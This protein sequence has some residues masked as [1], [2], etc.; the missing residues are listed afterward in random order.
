MTTLTFIENLRKIAEVLKP[1]IRPPQQGAL[2]W[3]GTS[4]VPSTAAFDPFALG[5]WGT[6]TTVADLVEAQGIPVTA[7]QREYLGKLFFGG[8]GSLNDFMLDAKTLGEPAREANAK[9]NDA[10][11]ELYVLFK[12]A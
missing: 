2:V 10:R 6:L 11:T 1:F 7:A 3:N 8:M 12:D 4:Y 9:L 5:W